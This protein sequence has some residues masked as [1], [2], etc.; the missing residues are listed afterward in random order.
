MTPPPTI[1]HPVSV[2]VEYSGGV[3]GC[4]NNINAS[5]SPKKKTAQS[6][7]SMVTPNPI[8][9]GTGDC[10]PVPSGS[11]QSPPRLR[12]AAYNKGAANCY[13]GVQTWK[14]SHQLSFC[15]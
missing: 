12:G 9:E 3:D 2:F 8:E 7:F 6:F 1:Q 11:R 13:P 4:V 14:A 15:K 5:A 10:A